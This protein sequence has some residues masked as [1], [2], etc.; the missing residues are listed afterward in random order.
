MTGT[1]HPTGSLDLPVSLFE[2]PV[3]PA[4]HK[5]LPS[6]KFQ[7]SQR[8]L[9]G[10]AFSA[11]LGRGR[12]YRA[13]TLTL[14]Y[15]PSERPR[16]GIAVPKKQVRL[17][18]NRNK[19]KRVLR[20]NFRR[21]AQDLPPFDLVVLCRAG[22]TDTDRLRQDFNRLLNRLANPIRPPLHV[23]HSAQQP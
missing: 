6:E 22:A 23:E 21:Q 14:V 4:Q 19:V 20:E 15:L 17:A 8:L 1:Q 18:V 11:V 5:P 13:D 9:D 16:L 2:N 10:K 7:R 12:R 3:L